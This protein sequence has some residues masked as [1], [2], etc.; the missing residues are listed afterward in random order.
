MASPRFRY[1][2]GGLTERRRLGLRSPDP[3]LR[4]EIIGDYSTTLSRISAL[5]IGELGCMIYDSDRPEEV[6]HRGCFA[7][8]QGAL[9]IAQVEEGWTNK[10]SEG[11]EMCKRSPS[12]DLR[13][14]L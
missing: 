13:R 11:V 6:R 7:N 3:Y 2:T 8:E 1:T 12:F 5:K 10:V 9:P 4:A 14:L